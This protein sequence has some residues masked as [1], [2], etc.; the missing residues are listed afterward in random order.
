MAL[1]TI[2]IETQANPDHAIIWLH[3][4]G[5]SGYDFEPIVEQLNLPESIR[6]R[7]IFPHA[8]I[9]AVSLN[10]GMAMPAWYD[11]FGLDIDSEEDIEGIKRIRPE[12]DALIGLQIETG[13]SVNKIVLAGFS[14]GGAL[15]LFSGLSYSHRLAGLIAL[16]AYLPIRHEL[17]E[18]AAEADLSLPVF[19]AH[20]SYDDIVPLEFA[21][22]AQK[23]L[24][25][26]GFTIDWKT[27][28]CAHTVCNEEIEDIRAWL[29]KC[30]QY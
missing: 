21:R 10:N 29:L 28:P 6:A 1:S 4:L 7:Y 26:R 9:Q 18:Y 17:Q 25:Q 20:G 23:S 22:I 16:S 5:A 30:W 27:Y 8:P 3:G 19:L 11:I 15:A 13:I 12:I 24:E 14:Q 2:Q